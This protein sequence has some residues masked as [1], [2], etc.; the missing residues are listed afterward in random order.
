MIQNCALLCVHKMMYV[1][2]STFLVSFDKIVTIWFF[3]KYFLENR[4]GTQ[5][6]DEIIELKNQTQ[7]QRPST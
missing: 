2:L 6:A 1:I 7:E 4:A 5:T 3:G